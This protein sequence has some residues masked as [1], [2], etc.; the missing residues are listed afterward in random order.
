MKEKPIISIITPAYNA[1]AYISAAIESVLAQ[2]FSDWELIIVDDCSQ[3][4]TASI[5]K[6]YVQKDERIQLLPLHENSGSAV[7][8]N[9][10]M[11][12][13]RGRYLA[14][15]DSD[16]LWL[17]EKL[18]TQLQFMQEKDHAFSFTSYVRMHED[19]TETSAIVKAPERLVYHDL[20]KQCV[21]GCLTVM[22]DRDQIGP[23]KM[24]NMRTRQDYAYWLKIMR[25]GHKAYGIPKVL[26][27]YR[28]VPDSISSNKLQAAK[29]N[30]HLY[31]HIEKQSFWKAAWYFSNYAVRSVLSILKYKFSRSTGK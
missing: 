9:T 23:L 4:E 27:K 19:G 7:A 30:W 8:R 10:A 25:N 2:T 28:L 21:I 20:M 16:D 31:R 15:L 14:F 11:D 13:A 3:D 24:P 12:H 29:K 17:P 5:V 18:A 22:L 6:T 26:A 1:A